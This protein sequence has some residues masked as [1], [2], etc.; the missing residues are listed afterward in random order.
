MSTV[1][2]FIN[3]YR[4]YF[5]CVSAMVLILVLIQTVDVTAVLPYWS[6]INHWLFV[7]FSLYVISLCLGTWRWR[8]FIPEVAFRSL[9]VTAWIGNFFSN[10]LPSSIGGDS[11]R[12]VALRELVGLKAVTTSVLLDRLA[13]VVAILFIGVP[14]S[15]I[16]VPTLIS[17]SLLFVMGAGIGFCSWLLYRLCR[18]NEKVQ[19]FIASLLSMLTSKGKPFMMAC[20]IS[21][22][23]LGLGAFSL[24]L[25]YLMFGYTLPFSLVIGLYAVLQLVELLP[26]SINSLGVRE[27]MLVF[28]FSIVGVPGEVSLG[29]A[30]LSRLVLL[31][32]TAIGGLLYLTRR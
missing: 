27:G 15:F 10:F 2:L 25:Y 6:Q 31:A 23:Y 12:V 32:Q 16:L 11:Y 8:L 29:I 14:T 9:F 28:L 3:T 17:S 1:I 19:V 24:W 4:W 5:K 7:I 21:V 30:I 20:F 22:A 26:I 18:K 13:G